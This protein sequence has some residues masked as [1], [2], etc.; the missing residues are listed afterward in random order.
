[1]ELVESHPAGTLTNWSSRQRCDQNYSP[2]VAQVIQK[3]WQGSQTLA[4]RDL[5][6]SDRP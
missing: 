6:E 4:H 3:V 5:K 1:M 2:W